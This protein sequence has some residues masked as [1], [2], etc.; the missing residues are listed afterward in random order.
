MNCSFCNGMDSMANYMYVDKN[1]NLLTESELSA[2]TILHPDEKVSF[3]KVIFCGICYN[4]LSRRTDRKVTLTKRQTQRTPVVTAKRPKPKNYYI[5]PF[6]DTANEPLRNTCKNCSRILFSTEYETKRISKGSYNKKQGSFGLNKVVLLVAILFATLYIFINN[7][8]EQTPRIAQPVSGTV[9]G[10]QSTYEWPDGT[11]YTGEFK[12]G[13]PNGKGTMT[14]ANGGTYTG[15]FLNGKI[16]GRG[17]LSMNGGVFEGS[18]VDGKPHGEGKMTYPDG[19]IYTGMWVNG[20]PG[21]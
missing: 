10:Q 15:D 17:K 7:S 1:N 12:N 16:T 14:W 9:M 21:S 11:K 5:C 8:G 19:S 18:L 20:K 2:F 13:Q 4:D 3:R 6:C